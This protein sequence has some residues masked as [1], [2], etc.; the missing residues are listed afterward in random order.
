MS[1]PIKQRLLVMNGQR[2]LQA[3]R[4]GQWAT[5]KVDKAM[6]IKPGIY[7]LHLARMADKS[8]AYDGVALFANKDHVFQLVGKAVLK[9]DRDQFESAP[10]TGTNLRIAY[11]GGKAIV[12]AASIKTGR[13]R[14]R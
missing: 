2:I 10:D 3:E 1:E 11:G 4:D 7:D 14:S 8:L 12:A 13:G 5:I 6:G 9:H